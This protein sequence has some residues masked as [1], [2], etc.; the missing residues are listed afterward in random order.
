MNVLIDSNDKFD[1]NA[2][3]ESNLTPQQVLAA[4]DAWLAQ[5]EKQENEAKEK[6]E[7]EKKKQEEERLKKE[8]EAAKQKEIEYC[9]RY[10]NETI[11]DFTE[12]IYSYLTTALDFNNCHVSTKEKETIMR[13]ANQII[14]KQISDTLG[15]PYKEYIDKLKNGNDETPIDDAKIDSIIAEFMSQK[16]LSPRQE[17]NIKETCKNLTPE[18][19]KNENANSSSETKKISAQNSDKAENKQNKKNLSISKDITAESQINIDT[20]REHA[21]KNLSTDKQNFQDKKAQSAQSK[22][23]IQSDDDVK[24]NDTIENLLI[25]ALTKLYSYCFDDDIFSKNNDENDSNQ[26]N[27]HCKDDN[28]RHKEKIFANKKKFQDNSVQRFSSKND[29]ILEPKDLLVIGDIISDCMDN[30]FK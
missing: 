20:N 24:D 2:M 17:K 11:E 29:T 5:K 7:L 10:I 6:L 14:M 4:I 27:A 1:L 23:D 9:I 12:A 8:A 19:E 25:D 22:N 26:V 30:L 28:R 13:A 16:K 3:R 18:C 15:G 21:R